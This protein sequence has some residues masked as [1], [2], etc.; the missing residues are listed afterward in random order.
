[1]TDFGI[2]LG[3][4]GVAFWLC[5]FLLLRYARKL[6]HLNSLAASRTT[7]PASERFTGLA[8]E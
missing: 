7:E 3:I 8:G 5:H 4:L 1:M 6:E 2:L